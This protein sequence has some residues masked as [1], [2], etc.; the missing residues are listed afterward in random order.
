VDRLAQDAQAASQQA[1]HQLA[2]DQDHTYE[3]RPERDKHWA[4]RQRVHRF[5]LGCV[6]VPAA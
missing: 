3:H 5:T 1:D 6:F 4:A 2:H